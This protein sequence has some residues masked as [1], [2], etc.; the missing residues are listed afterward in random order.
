M[1]VAEGWAKRTFSAAK[2]KIES[3]AE[4]TGSWPSAA[5]PMAEESDDTQQVETAAETV[6]PPPPAST[7]NPPI[8]IATAVPLTGR[9]QP[10][11]KTG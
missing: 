1:K 11:S 2:A 6:L 9:A 3:R 10:V 5:G 4:R 7:S 8:A